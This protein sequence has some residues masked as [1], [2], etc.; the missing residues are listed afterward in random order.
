MSVTPLDDLLSVETLSGLIQT[1]VDQAENRSC[2]ALFSRAA[3]PLFP[4]GDSATWD[5][6]EFSRHLAPVSG[7]DSPHTRTKRLGRRKRTSAMA[8]VKVYKDLPAPH[9]FLNRA[10]GADTA[11]A[12][13]VL[14][15]ELED[16]A[17]LIANTKEFL[18]CGALLGKIDVN[19]QLVPGSDVSF[20]VEFGN[21]EAQ[22]QNSWADP[23]TKIRSAELIRL[24]RL[25]K[26]Q[27]GMRAEV[28]VT[29]PTVEGYL[30]QNDEIREF[31]K[32]PLGDVIL[33]NLTLT[34]VNPQWERLA[35]LSWRFTDGTYKPEGGPVTR[36][37]PA[38]HVLVLP[39]E[40][41]LQQVLG[42]AE[43]KVHVPSGPV[44]SAPEAA[45]SM[46]T[47]LRGSYAYAKVRDDPVGIRVYAGWYGLPVVL[48]PNAVMVFRVVPQAPAP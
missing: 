11:D 16:M 41:R 29:E 36:Y 6:I 17:N 24:K 37:F 21:F 46:L 10:P 22:A 34:G 3:R 14:T 13:A 45:T 39:A 25:F 4:L 32:E 43:G 19:P 18:A 28:G 30:V 48:N 33:R 35:G 2:S 8:M 47:E 44:I 26:D 5:E 42:W 7:P 20:T 31:A 1:F 38:D 40:Q 12:E 9:L 23:V 27:S 15:A